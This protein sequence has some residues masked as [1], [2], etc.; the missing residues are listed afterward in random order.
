VREH[1]KA[2][3]N[4]NVPT[5]KQ[6]SGWLRRGLA[7]VMAFV[8]SFAPL[9]GG[10]L[11]PAA[12]AKPLPAPIP[13][14]GPA[15]GCELNSPKGNI[16]HVVT[17]IFD[18]THF[19][20]DPARN[21]STLVPSDLEQMPHLL[22]FIKNNGVLLTDHHTPLISHT[23]DDI[24]TILTGVYP[25]RHGVATA[26][27]SYQEYKTDGTTQFQSGFTYWTDLSGD[28]SYNLIS[29]AADANHPNGVNA[30]APW[31]PFTRAGCDVGAVAAADMEIENTGVDLATVFGPG[32][33]QTT[34]PHAF[35]NYEGVAIHCSATSTLCSI[36]N[37]GFPDKLPWE[38]NADGSPATT[39]RTGTSTAYEGYNA[40]FGHKYV[41]QAF[42]TLGV[43]SKVLD[44]NGNLLDINGNTIVDDFPAGTLT[45]GFPGFSLPPQYSLGYTADMLEAG[46]PVVYSYIITPHRPLPSNPYA[47][48]FPAD[49][50]DYGP[51]EAHY[52]Q[53][54]RQYDDAF[55]K[56]FTRLGN[57]GITPA[58]TLFVI[59]SEEGD[60]VV[61]ANPTNFP[62]DGVTTPC[63]Y[64]NTSGNEVGELA[65]NFRGLLQAETGITTSAT[66]TNDDAPGIYLTGNPVP[67]DPILRA[68]E[69]ASGTLTITNPIS[70][71]T[72]TL[73]QDMANPAEFKILHMQTFDPLRTPSFTLFANP[74]YYVTGSTACGTSAT[75]LTA[76]VAQTP[77]FAW[78]HGDVQPQITTI[79]LGMAG[80]GVTVK[81]VD[82]E[83]WSD[84]TDVRPTMLV[85]LGLEDDYASQGRALVEELQNRALP[86][87]VAGSGDAFTELARAYKKIN[88]PV[89]ELGLASLRVSTRAL[90]GDDH[91][92]SKLENK[93][94][95]VT[96]TRDTLADAMSQLLEGA[97]FGGKQISGRDAN[98]LVGQS[99]QLLE[100]VGSLGDD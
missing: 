53:T 6:F 39:D 4:L 5:R 54:L 98:M 1:F 33:L 35:A 99:R 21:G 34:D 31:V 48:G 11:A 100:Y 40:L 68:Y 92:Y 56:F 84:H 87:G 62:C 59:T 67:A 24:I 77:G 32:S 20:R 46:I 73:A 28:N 86:A 55:N 23:S 95:G 66:V 61:A 25:S 12:Q 8:L 71:A 47:Y 27:N 72:D 9:A 13:I 18:N 70:G 3:L 44:N 60:H 94:S 64:G 36:A 81:G 43:G 49:G 7:V 42:Q 90:A 80:P 38:P 15:T 58:N 97:E 37:G 30:P 75:P 88:A 91:T 29:G 78:N 96:S 50:N 22:N 79:W 76:C 74:D 63:T 14:A 69:R 52:V 82:E 45:P 51:G 85:L 16:K 93:L 10:L 41:T 2:A 19:Q 26:A 83:T 89:G 65:L 17:I 57:D